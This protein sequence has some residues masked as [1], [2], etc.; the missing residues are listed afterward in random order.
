MTGK[1]K[2]NNEQSPVEAAQSS[3]CSVIILSNVSSSGAHQNHLDHF[4]KIRESH[5]R[6]LQKCS[7]KRIIIKK[8]NLRQL[9]YLVLKETTTGPLEKKIATILCDV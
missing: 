9:P 2:K 4:L 1:K 3:E 8:K 6:N 7:L 5:P